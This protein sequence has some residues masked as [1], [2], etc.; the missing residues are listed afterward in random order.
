ML[1]L[2]TFKWGLCLQVPKEIFKGPQGRGDSPFS[3]LSRLLL[4]GQNLAIESH[5]VLVLHVGSLEAHGHLLQ[6]GD[7]VHAPPPV[8]HHA[9]SVQ[10]Q[11]TWGPM[12]C[13]LPSVLTLDQPVT[14]VRRAALALYLI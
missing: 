7:A 9:Q 8:L 12:V 1:P 11:S 2:Q 10:E 3:Q 5:Q 4:L 6:A 13:M 14:A